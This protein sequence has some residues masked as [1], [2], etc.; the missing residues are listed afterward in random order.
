M[1]G[2]MAHVWNLMNMMQIVNTFPLYQI[3]VP[4]NVIQMQ[5]AFQKFSNV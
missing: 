3:K 2:A 1:S 5:I 4:E